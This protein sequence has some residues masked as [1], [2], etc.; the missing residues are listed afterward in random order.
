MSEENKAL[1]R[2]FFEAVSRGDID[3]LEEVISPDYVNHDP[4]F[5]ADT[6]GIEGVKETMQ[7]Y[8]DAFPDINMKVEDQIAEGDKVFTRW[9]AEGTHEGEL[10]GV[11]PSGKRVH[12]EGMTIDRIEDGK[13]VETWDNWDALGMMQQMGAIPASQPA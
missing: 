8:L 4:V 3:W 7:G 6:H 1:S 12:V 13:F 11:P 9:V 2:R 10:F 5:P